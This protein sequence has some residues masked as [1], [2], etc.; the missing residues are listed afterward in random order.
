MTQLRRRQKEEIVKQTL[1]RVPQAATGVTSFNT[2]S[3]AV[4]GLGTDIPAFVLS[5]P[6]HAPGAVPDPGAVAGVTK[7]LREDAS[8]QVPVTVAAAHHATHEN[9]GTDQISLTGLTGVTGTPQPPIIGAGA[10]QAVAGNDSRLSD[11]RTPLAHVHPTTDVTSGRFIGA[12]ML[13]G[14]LGLDLRGNGAG[15]DPTYQSRVS[16]RLTADNAAIVAAVP[17]TALQVANLTVAALINDEWDLEWVLDIANSI[18]ADVFVFNV[19]STV[20]TLTGRYTVEG[21][22]GVPNTGAGTLKLWSMPAG[23]LTLATANAP[24][25]TGTIGLVLTVVVRARVK[26]TV[27]NAT[28]QLLLR[29]G[30]NA[31][32][33]SGTAV[34]KAQSQLIARKVA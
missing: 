19:T 5:G 10:A 31:A 28:I 27:A 4:V 14:G 1:A 30:T 29:A 11:P 17:T 33:S 26:L 20:G 23:T 21:T 24:G 15:V 13:D 34:V 6:T 8:W 9:G 3:G 32:L 12:R 25:A 2:R 16:V 18:A 22:T 7:F